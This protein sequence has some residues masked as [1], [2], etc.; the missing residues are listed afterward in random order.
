MAEDQ[1]KKDEEKFEFTPEGETLG[2]IGMDQA[3]VRAMQVASETPGDY[4]SAYSGVR[5]AFEVVSAQE[6]EDH[7]LITLSLRPQGNFSGRPGQE[8]FFI[9]KEGTVAH[10]QVLALP[11]QGRRFPVI[12]VAIGLAVAGVVAVIA[13]LVAGGLGRGDDIQPGDTASLPTAT[14]IPGTQTALPPPTEAQAVAP[15]GNAI[16]TP[17]PTATPRP[18]PTSTSVPTSTSRPTPTPTSVPTATPRPTATP[19]PEPT[20]TPT[21]TPTP[22]GT[23]TPIHATSRP[24]FDDLVEFLSAT[25]YGGTEDPEW[26][27]VRWLIFMNSDGVFQP[28]L[29]TKTFN[30]QVFGIITVHQEDGGWR[31]F[32]L[33]SDA[34]SVPYQ[35]QRSYVTYASLDTYAAASAEGEDLFFT[36]IRESDQIW[37]VTAETFDD[38]TRYIDWSRD[39]RAQDSVFADPYSRL[40]LERFWASEAPPD[41]TDYLL[42]YRSYKEWNGLE[43]LEHF[44][45]LTVFARYAPIFATELAMPEPLPGAPGLELPSLLGD[46]HLDEYFAGP[47]GSQLLNHVEDLK[48][49]RSNIATFDTVEALDTH[50]FGFEVL[51][52]SGSASGAFPYID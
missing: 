20:V 38:L 7:Y 11:R 12:P 42:I 16:P 51:H 31:E 4:G 28:N 25:F 9:E 2:Y 24:S 18:T 26:Q 30:D 10:R 41:P 8:Q 44:A 1:G 35:S 34:A 23:P 45:K 22:M 3:H 37:T 21:P 39:N 32:R 50:A 52:M 46:W 29:R 47:E 19:T 14:P 13:V 27:G 33:Y 6:T 43:R 5:M 49:S 48:A 40:L 36:S 17:V 15:S